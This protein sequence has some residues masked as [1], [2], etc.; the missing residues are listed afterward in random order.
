MK[1]LIFI[2]F[3]F[4]EEQRQHIAAFTR[5]HSLETFRDFYA[6][7]W[8]KQQGQE[9]LASY[10]GRYDDDDEPD[11][12]HQLVLE[13][14]A[15]EVTLTHKRLDKGKT[16]ALAVAMADIGVDESLHADIDQ[17][18]D[19]TPPVNIK[20]KQPDVLSKYEERLRK[21]LFDRRLRVFSRRF[22]RVL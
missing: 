4:T 2:D 12:S 16:L 13:F 20:S 7:A 14:R 18:L 22:K 17:L 9:L 11:G 5:R 6:L 8:V 15:G 10:L 1:T 3:A 19:Y 21:R